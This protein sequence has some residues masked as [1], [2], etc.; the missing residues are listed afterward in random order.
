M[1][2]AGDS[3]RKG[4]ILDAIEAAPMPEGIKDL[5]FAIAAAWDPQGAA[6]AAAAEAAA[7]A[8]PGLFGRL[9]SG[10]L[11]QNEFIVL[12]GATTSDDANVWAQALIALDSDVQVFDAIMDTASWAPVP[13]HERKRICLTLLEALP[14]TAAREGDHYGERYASGEYRHALIALALHDLLAP[15]AW[16]ETAYRHFEQLVARGPQASIKYCDR[17]RAPA[18]PT[19]GRWQPLEPPEDDVDIDVKAGEKREGLDAVDVDT[20]EVRQAYWS[21]LTTGDADLDQ[22][23]ESVRALLRAVWMPW[24]AAHPE[25]SEE[26][27]RPS[28]AD[29]AFIA[30][31]AS[32]DFRGFLSDAYFEYGAEAL[33]AAG[34]LDRLAYLLAQLERVSAPPD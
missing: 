12:L 34:Q 23:L 8:L 3:E 21:E 4:T 32:A 1:A 5:W 26:R 22:E 31:C 30:V 11:D 7:P 16:Q 27:K 20:G 9:G 6:F 10:E 28:V 15:A 2:W 14:V 17:E 24:D 13:T 25:G 19:A 29:N 18:G 33:L